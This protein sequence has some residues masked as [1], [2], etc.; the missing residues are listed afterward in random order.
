VNPATAQT[1]AAPVALPVRTVRTR[2]GPATRQTSLIL[3]PVRKVPRA[4]RRHIE[5]ALTVWGLA[6]LTDLAALI[7]SELVTNAIAAS[8]STTPPGKEGR[9]VILSMTARDGELLIRVWDADPAMPPPDEPA[10]PDPLPE[11]GRG[12]II[13]SELSRQWG[14]HP[15]NGGKFVW[16]SLPL[17]PPPP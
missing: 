14:W 11:D 8:A 2:P 6:H 15:G 16:A 3:A 17:S 9:P 4:A 5:A 12:L 13:V 7:T 10:P 1:D